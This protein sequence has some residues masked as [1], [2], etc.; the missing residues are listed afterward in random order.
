MIPKGLSQQQQQTVGYDFIVEKAADDKH[1]HTTYAKRKKS[2]AANVEV[3]E[4]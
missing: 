1:D 3:K 4:Q 2:S